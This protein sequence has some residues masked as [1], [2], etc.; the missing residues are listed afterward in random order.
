MHKPPN[1]PVDYFPDINHSVTTKI[2]FLELQT[3]QKQTYP[4]EVY[5]CVFL[6]EHRKQVQE[7]SPAF[8]SISDLGAHF[9][10][11]SLGQAI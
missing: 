10:L 8:K 7:K 1:K 2:L 9:F 11:R 4:T 3:Q 5:T 6:P